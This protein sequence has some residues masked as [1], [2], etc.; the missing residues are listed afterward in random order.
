MIGI[1]DRKYIHG[2]SSERIALP[3]PGILVY[4]EHKSWTAN[5]FVL[6][7]PDGLYY[8]REGSF[9]AIPDGNTRINGRYPDWES[10]TERPIDY[11]VY[12]SSALCEMRELLKT[13]KVSVR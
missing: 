1:R 4:H 12:G 5:H 10:K 13:Q 8:F 9:V 6:M 7:L 2:G 3:K 11:L